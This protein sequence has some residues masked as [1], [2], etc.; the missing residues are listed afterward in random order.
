MNALLRTPATIDLE[1]PKDTDTD[2]VLVEEVD[3]PEGDRGEKDARGQIRQAHMFPF[4]EYDQC[5]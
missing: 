5:P 4:L 1:P 2:N 3:D